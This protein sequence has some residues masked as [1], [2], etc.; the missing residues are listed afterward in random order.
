MAR[1]K[2][3]LIKCKECGKKMTA[4]AKIPDKATWDILGNAIDAEIPN[5]K[6]HN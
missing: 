6:H 1:A 5:C 4:Y 2:I 3:R